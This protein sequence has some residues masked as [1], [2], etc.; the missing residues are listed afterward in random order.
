MM[1]QVSVAG[2]RPQLQVGT[3]TDEIT[4]NLNLLV[5]LSESESSEEFSSCRRQPESTTEHDSA[6]GPGSAAADRRGGAVTT[7]EAAA[8]DAESPARAGPRRGR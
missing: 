6:T 4:D 7:G 2:P 5:T 1:I 8:S 3:W